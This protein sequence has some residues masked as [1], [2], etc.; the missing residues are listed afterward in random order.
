[1]PGLHHGH[2][3]FAQARRIVGP[4]R[5]SLVTLHDPLH[6]DLL[7]EATLAI[8]EGRDPSRGGP[9]LRRPRAIV[10]PGDLPL[11]DAA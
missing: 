2:D 3:L 1:M 7:S 11:F 10:R 9:P 6:D 5:T 4:R 8:L